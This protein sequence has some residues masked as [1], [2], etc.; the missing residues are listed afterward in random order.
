MY[1]D[2]AGGWPGGSAVVPNVDPSDHDARELERAAREATEMFIDAIE[3][4]HAA[5]ESQLA[6]RRAVEKVIAR[7]Q[8]SYQRLAELMGI[9]VDT[10]ENL[11]E[12]EPMGLH[13]R[14]RVS[15]DSMKAL[16]EGIA[17]RRQWESGT[18]GTY[19]DRLHLDSVV[20][21]TLLT[22]APVGFAILDPDLRYV[23]VNQA[24]ADINGLRVEEHLGRT[25]FEVVP[26]IA[27]E[28]VDAFQKVLGSGEPLLNLELSGSVNSTPDQIRRWYESVYRVTDNRG[29]LG[30]AV[31]VVEIDA[32]S[33]NGAAGAKEVR[34]SA[35]RKFDVSPNKREGGW[36]VR[37]AGSSERFNTKTMAIAS[38]TKSAKQ[39]GNAQV[40]IRKKDGSIQSERTYGNDPRRSKG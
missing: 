11:L 29:V 21:R 30:L 32:G 34:M 23:L 18:R 27:P 16:L 4:A 9:S 28:A 3:F 19:L 37:S 26:D 12:H 36:I 40:V 17:K 1:L 8:V 31:I 24:L 7:H 25:L 5:Y 33:G 2:D 14:L 13:E 38:A 22:R 35:R 10:V 6:A 20:L 15:E 39:H